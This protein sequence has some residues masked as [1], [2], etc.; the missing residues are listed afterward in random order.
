M[1]GQQTQPAA[2]VGNGTVSPKTATSSSPANA[3]DLELLPEDGEDLEAVR[4]E[5]FSLVYKANR[6]KGLRGRLRRKCALVSA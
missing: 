4:A 6:S 2:A 5:P 1:A 3:L